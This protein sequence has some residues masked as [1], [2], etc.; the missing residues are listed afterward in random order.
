MRAR[1]H[2][3]KAAHKYV[4]R[5]ATGL[6]AKTY[7]SALERSMI[8]GIVAWIGLAA[9]YLLFAGQ[10]SR[11]EVIAGLGASLLAAAYAVVAH[12]TTDAKL[13]LRLPWLRVIGGVATDLVVDTIGV[14]ATLVRPR[15]GDLSRRPLPV[16][17]GRRAVAILAASVAPNS[18][19]VGT[20]RDAMVMH[21]LA[22]S[23]GTE[24]PA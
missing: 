23:G 22:A 6:A 5:K 21:R 1:R 16:Q 2:A 17:P 10:V 12:R 8:F 20:D 18:Y 9:T 24:T 19:V 11:N 7:V 3:V 13:R 4:R 14:G 15:A